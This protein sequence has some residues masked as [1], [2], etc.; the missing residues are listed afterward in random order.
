MGAGLRC[1]R[2]HVFEFA[3]LEVESVSFDVETALKHVTLREVARESSASLPHNAELRHRPDEEFSKKNDDDI[4]LCATAWITISQFFF[5]GRRS[6]DAPLIPVPR[7]AGAA[8][9]SF[10]WMSFDFLGNVESIPSSLG[11]ISS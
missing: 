5:R 4:F 7:T 2:L 1:D 9:V 11:A 8:S 6:C 10:S 3:V